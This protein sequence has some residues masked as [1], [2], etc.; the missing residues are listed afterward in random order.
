VFK[1]KITAADT[2]PSGQTELTLSTGEKMLCDLYLPC[3]GVTPN[4]SFMPKNL[5]D[6][7]GSIMVD[8]YM[9]VKGTSDIWS[10]GDAADIEAKRV[11]YV[12]EQ[13]GYLGK[14]LHSVLTTGKKTEAPYKPNPKPM[15]AVTVGR[16]KGFGQMG[17][18]S[19]PS[20]LVM[21]VKGKTM[22]VENLPKVI[23]GTM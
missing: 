1:K 9:A 3:V 5:L 20:F 18:W 10:C 8:E 16:A 19:L 21:Y 14:T 2:L 23:N 17:S 12:G 13:T 22:M 4:T 6:A 7:Q 11:M 15:G